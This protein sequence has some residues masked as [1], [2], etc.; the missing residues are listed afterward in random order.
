MPEQNNE[1]E[2]LT[3]DEVV[4]LLSDDDSPN[5]PPVRKGYEDYRREAEAKAS[6]P[7]TTEEV[8]KDDEL[9]IDIPEKF[10]G[11]SAAEIAKSYMELQSEYGRR[12]NEVGSLRKLTDQLL[13]LKT[14]ETK[15]EPV[16]EIDVEN[17]LENPGE[18]INQAV[19][20][21][22][23][24]KAIEEKL[25]KAD[26]Q[27]SLTR[28][29]DK[30]PKWKETLNTKEFQEWVLETPVRQRLFVEANNNYDYDT[31]S[32]LFDMY[33]LAKG[34]AVEDATQERDT[35]AR[36]AAKQAVTESGGSTETKGKPKYKRTELI[37]LKL[38]NPAK[39]NAMLDKIMSAYADGRVI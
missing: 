34:N 21:N 3:H 25:T 17:L 28:F 14:Q 38:S 39:Y 12:N 16:K 18:A 19:D 2:D 5:S 15:E 27:D 10:K 35:R 7:A 32:E 8:D 26:R 20:G 1:Q 24:L 36:Q 29:E 37:Q 22:P 11:K 4:S 33:N 31:G 13:E 30:H 9:D 23:R 6:T